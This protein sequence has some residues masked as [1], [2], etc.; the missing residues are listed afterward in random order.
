MQAACCYLRFS[1]VGLVYVGGC[2]CV[3]GFFLLCV[4]VGGGFVCFFLKPRLLKP[5]VLI[6][7][8]VKIPLVDVS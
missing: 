8:K 5:L 3:C 2:V 6:F 1:V 4:F 7:S